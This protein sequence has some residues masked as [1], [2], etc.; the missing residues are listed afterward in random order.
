MTIVSNKNP[1]AVAVLMNN[2]NVNTR[3]SILAL[4]SRIV[5]HTKINAPVDTGRLRSSVHF[6]SSSRP[7]KVLK[8]R[9]D[10][11]RSD[12]PVPS[13]FWKSGKGLNNQSIY[14]HVATSYAAWIEFI[15]GSKKRFLLRGIKTAIAE[16]NRRGNKFKVKQ[17]AT[18]FSLPQ[19]LSFH[20]FR[21]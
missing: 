2:M 4:A 11:G 14:V 21:R 10:K 15:H 8:G 9:L 5:Y 13:S 18:S 20:N 1:A 7:K 6:S 12:A 16:M 3:Q 17:S 19:A